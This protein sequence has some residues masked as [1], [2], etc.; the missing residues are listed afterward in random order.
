M[1]T[2]FYIN[3]K[4]AVQRRIELEKNFY[5]N[6]DNTFQ[7]HRIEAINK[8]QITTNTRGI[9]KTDKAV[10][11]SHLDALRKAVR[12]KRTTLIMEDDTALFPETFSTIRH[13]ENI[14]NPQIPIVIFTDIMVTTP[15]GM[16]EFCRLPKNTSIRLLN[17]SRIQYAGASSYLVTPSAAKIMEQI[18]ENCLNIRPWDMTLRQII[19]KKLVFGR[20]TFPFVT[21]VNEYAEQS[22]N[23]PKHSQATDYLWNTFR[24]SLCIHPEQFNLHQALH[25]IENTFDTQQYRTLATIVAAHASDKFVKK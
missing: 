18:A 2:C 20:V 19:H 8:A 14:L 10:N 13:I 24:R 17:L 4:T 22:D 23:Q 9:S 15:N 11:R 7:L 1:I 21:S 6:A 25:K 5:A 16:V 12:L 3:L